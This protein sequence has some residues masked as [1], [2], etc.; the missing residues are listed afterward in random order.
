MKKLALIAFS[1]LLLVPASHNAFAAVT[2]GEILYGITGG[3]EV[4]A[5]YEFYQLTDGPNFGFIDFGPVR[6]SGI[7]FDTD[8][9]LY[10][11]APAAQFSVPGFGT[12]NPVD[13]SYTD[14][15]TGDAACNDIGIDPTDGQLYCQKKGQLWALDKTSGLLGSVEIGSTGIT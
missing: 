15:A 13:G 8:G 9:T 11:A 10:T 1:I 14:I 2:P 7:E 3:Q 12:I 4:E 5:N 6:S